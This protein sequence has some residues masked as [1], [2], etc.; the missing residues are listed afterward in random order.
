MEMGVMRKPLSR[1]IAQG[2]SVDLAPVSIFALTMCCV[3]IMT[4]L[5]YFLID[6]EKGLTQSS[7]RGFA[8][9]KVDQANPAM[10]QERYQYSYAFPKVPF[11]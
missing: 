7:C 6:N 8:R 11:C 2:L 9:D 10:L 4:V 3:L 5:L 1:R